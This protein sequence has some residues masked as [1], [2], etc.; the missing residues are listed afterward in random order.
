MLRMMA[1]IGTENDL[2]QTATLTSVFA[3]LNA[4][5]SKLGGNVGIYG[6][7]VRLPFKQC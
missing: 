5:F 2:C 4:V 3:I 6:F 7:F 1:E